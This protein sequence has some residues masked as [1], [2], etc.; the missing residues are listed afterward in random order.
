[1]KPLVAVTILAVLA[2][3]AILAVA[4]TAPAAEVGRAGVGGWTDQQT[5]FVVFTSDCLSGTPEPTDDLDGDFLDHSTEK[6]I[7]TDPCNPD[8]DGD[9]CSDGLEAVGTPEPVGPDPLYFWDFYDTPDPALV[10]GPP[11]HQRDR[12]I[13]IADIFRV[14][15][16]FGGAGTATSVDDA[17]AAAPVSGYHAGYDRSEPPEGK[18]V[19]PADGAISIEDVFLVAGQFGLTCK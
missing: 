1:M 10:G 16:R 13:N 19:G 11:D 2:G 4:R 18:L 12:S 9:G 14:A 6:G 8:T 5:S 15:G 7:G 3:G 17:L